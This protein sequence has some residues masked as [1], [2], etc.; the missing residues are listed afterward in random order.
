[1]R[2]SMMGSRP[3]KEPQQMKRMLVVSTWMNSC[4]GR[5]REPSGGMDHLL[6][7]DHLEERLLHALAADVAG[8]AEGMSPL[9]AILSISSM[10][11]M[12]RLGAVDVAVGGDPEVLDDVLDV[13]A[14]IASLG[15]AG[16]VRDGEGH[17]QAPRQGLGHQG[18][19]RAR[20][21]DQ[22]DVPLAELDVVVEVILAVQLGLDSFIVVV[23][24]DRERLLGA[25]LADDVLIEVGLDLVRAQV[26]GGLLL[27]GRRQLRVLFNDLLAQGDA[28]ITDM[29]ALRARDQLAD[30]LGLLP[31]EGA[32]HPAVALVGHIQD[33]MLGSAPP[34]RLRAT[35][36]AP[37]IFPA[38]A[39]R[40]QR[41]Q[42]RSPRAD[43]STRQPL[44]NRLDIPAP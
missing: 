16:R 43:L 9:R 40:G 4:W 20:G 19:A 26:V 42:D 30:V 24:G 34:W 25:V 12:P 37:G 44:W 33:S 3:S 15:E 21:A 22:E 2:R 8:G 11:T 31:A 28:L 1:M 7:L 5:L 6:R 14:D 38:A 36:E 27:G 18:L 23:D 32:A 10:Q 29:D 39:A 13:L 35:A 41:R 17:V